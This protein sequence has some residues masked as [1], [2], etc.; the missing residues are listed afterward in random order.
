MSSQATN[1]SILKENPNAMPTLAD[2]AMTGA[3]R[4][5]GSSLDYINRNLLQETN[6]TPNLD[7]NI[8]LEIVKTI[9][10][11]QNNSTSKSVVNCDRDFLTS[12]SADY[13]YSDEQVPSLGSFEPISHPHYT[14]PSARNQ[15]STFD[16]DMEL[17]SFGTCL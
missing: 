6:S 3:I 7:E 16:S 4:K 15:G 13:T 5:T 9:I 8:I 14:I 11:L 12:R 1:E 10:E 17:F 2:G